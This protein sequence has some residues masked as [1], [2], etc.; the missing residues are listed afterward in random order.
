MSG[1]VAATDAINDLFAM[2]V[3]ERN[4]FDEAF[5]KQVGRLKSQ[6]K[7]SLADCCAIALTQNLGGELLTSDHHE[8]DPITALGICKITFIR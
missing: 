4:D 6:N 1:E 8:L 7:V 3:I 2:S 5:W